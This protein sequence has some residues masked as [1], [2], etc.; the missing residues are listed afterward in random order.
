[1]DYFS[2]PLAVAVSA[3]DALFLLFG[4]CFFVAE[5]IRFQRQGALSAGMLAPWHAS[6]GELL[7]F[8]GMFVL[9]LLFF[10]HVGFALAGFFF[11]EIDLRESPVYATG[12]YQPIVL[13]FVLGACLIGKI[14]KKNILPFPPMKISQGWNTQET[15]SVVTRLS[16]RSRENVWAFFGL[17]LFFVVIASLISNCV[18]LLFPALKE[19]WE[20]NQILVDNLKSLEHPGILFLVVPSLVIFTPIIEEILFRAGIYRLLRAKMSGIPA[21]L[22]ASLCFAILHD[23]FSG[24]LPLTALSCILCYAYERTGKLAIPIIMHGLF[25]LNSLF[26]IFA[27]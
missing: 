7:Q 9:S 23:S 21:A 15:A 22:L 16:L 12:F 6:T 24:I 10:P 3:V 17:M 25:N 11:P 18:P 2:G 26:Q 19:A 20:Q 13:L 4:F 14:S 1:M 27:F 8:A 5:I